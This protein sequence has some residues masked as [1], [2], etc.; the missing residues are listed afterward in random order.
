MAEKTSLS[1]QQSRISEEA[2]QLIRNTF[3]DKDDLLLMIRDL[4][5]GF[6][7]SDNELDTLKEL[8][9]IPTLKEILSDMFMPQLRKDV[10]LGQSV[11]L[12]MTIRFEPI[13]HSETNV[14]AREMMLDKLEKALALM[15]NPK[16]GAITLE[17]GSL[18]VESLIAR[19]AYI[20]HIEMQLQAIRAI[21]SQKP[22]QEFNKKDS[23]K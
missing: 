1:V 6:K 4:F 12:W 8:F 19:T 20:T 16:N 18:E 11:D 21:A 14:T 9:K 13:E 5:F 10:P 3:K 17:V 7:L 15:D 2:R 23:A 22:E